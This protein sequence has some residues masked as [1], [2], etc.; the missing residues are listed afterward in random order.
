MPPDDPSLWGLVARGGIGP[1]RLLHAAERSV[2]LTSLATRTS[3]GGSSLDLAG[4]NVLLA[5]KDQLP[6]ALALIE[7]DGLAHRLVLC[8][9]DV[10]KEH[11]GPI[12]AAAAIDA[13]V[14]DGRLEAADLPGDLP[15]VQCDPALPSPARR[16]EG[17]SCPT[18]WIL[19]TSGTTGVP[20][21]VVHSLASLT[22]PIR[23]GTA[24]GNTGGVWST[25]YDIRRYGG[26]QVFLRA[27]LGGGSLVLSSASENV[28]DFLTRAGEAGVV[29]I[30]GTPSHWRR[31]LMSPAAGRIAPRYVRLSG[32]IA[33]QAI[34]DHLAVC[35][36]PAPVGH[37]FATTEAGVAFEVNDGLAGFPASVLT[38]GGEVEMK[39]ADGSLRIRS[40]RTAAGYLGPAAAPL[41]DADGFVDTGDIIEQR[42]ERCY[43]AGRRGGIINVGGNKVHPEEVEAVINRHPAV[44]MSLVKARKNPFTGAVVAAEVVLRS[45]EEG[46]GDTLRAAILDACRR[47]L[48]PYKVPATIKFVD[49]LPVGAAG[50]LARA[51]A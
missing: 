26:L 47:H 24:A 43:F 12:C 31:A 17:P 6:S 7:L 49:T 21:L 29:S 10:P 28:A 37:A 3:L 48:A 41:R 51:D 33:D 8:P 50:K 42:G 11:I 36:C 15:L 44:R 2:P 25:F 18:E 30:S 14:S 38:R 27:A 40:P 16:P 32:E 22:G 5:T 19:L 46:A 13:V 9:P 39:I 20:K 4:A 23:P 1:G 45:A 34:L 35:Y